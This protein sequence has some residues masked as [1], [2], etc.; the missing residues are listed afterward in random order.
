VD[1]SI[2]SYVLACL[3]VFGIITLLTLACLVLRN[4]HGSRFGSFRWYWRSLRLKQLSALAT[5]FFVAMAASYGVI[6][7]AWA[8][9]YIVIALKTATWWF[10]YSVNMRA[11]A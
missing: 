2:F 3:G 10:R 4:Y 11:R 8:L 7:D 5:M 6:H 9:F 1:T